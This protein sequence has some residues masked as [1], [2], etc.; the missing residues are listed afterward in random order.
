MLTA[1]LDLV[2]PPSTNDTTDPLYQRSPRG[3]GWYQSKHHSAGN[4]SY[5]QRE[6]ERLHAAFFYGNSGEIVPVCTR[7]NTTRLSRDSNAVESGAGSS[8]G[9]AHL[10]AAL[11][12]AAIALTF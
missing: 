2:G 11:A 4:M 8:R 6:N 12:L 1:C 7:V 10:S 5:Y 9:S 3:F